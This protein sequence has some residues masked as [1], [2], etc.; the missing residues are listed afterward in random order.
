M[1]LLLPLGY[2]SCHKGGIYFSI[3]SILVSKYRRIHRWSLDGKFGR[4]SYKVSHE[5]GWNFLPRSTTTLVA[6]IYSRRIL[7]FVGVI[8]YYM[9]EVWTKRTKKAR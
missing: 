7:F 5:V 3:V 4:S 1:N 8:M 6:Q 9:C 2:F